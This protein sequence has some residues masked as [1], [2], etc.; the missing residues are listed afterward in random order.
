MGSREKGRKDWRER[1][2]EWEEGVE[3]EGAKGIEERWEEGRGRRK[4]RG[5][6]RDR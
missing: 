4:K 1:E 2:R 6:W 5:R 3:L